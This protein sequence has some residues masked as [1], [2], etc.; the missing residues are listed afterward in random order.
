MIQLREQADERKIAARI[1][2]RHDTD[3]SGAIRYALGF[4]DA[5]ER[6]AKPNGD[7]ATMTT[8]EL[9]TLTIHG[10]DFYTRAAALDAL[11]AKVSEATK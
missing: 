1:A 5:A 7:M 10:Y 3:L 2:K 9:R 6:T 4:T 11:L 8:E